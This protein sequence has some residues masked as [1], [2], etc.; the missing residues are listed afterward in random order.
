ML[1]RALSHIIFVPRTKPLPVLSLLVRESRMLCEQFLALD[2]IG[3]FYNHQFISQPDLLP[4][5]G[6]INVWEQWHGLPHRAESTHRNREIQAKRSVQLVGHSLHHSYA[7]RELES[8]CFRHSKPEETQWSQ[9]RLTALG[10]SPQHLVTIVIPGFQKQW[11][12]TAAAV[13]AA[14]ISSPE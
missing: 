10:F 12:W 2:L 4:Q 3:G 11:I 6:T 9:W 13:N 8:Y 7:R 1:T 5:G 14:R